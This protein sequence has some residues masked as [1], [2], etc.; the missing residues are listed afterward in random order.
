VRRSAPIF[1]VTVLAV[2]TAVGALSGCGW[3]KAGNVSHIKPS[4]FVLRGYVSV[5]RAP[6]GPTGSPCQ[7]PSAG[8]TANDPVVVTDP[9]DHVLATGVLG[10]GV[11]AADGGGYRC[12]FPFQISGVAGGHGSYGISPAGRPAVIFAATELRQ[13]KPAVIGVD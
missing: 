3:V 1:A 4:G 10:S 8:I 11:L 12:N 13:D 2:T 5:A 9:A 6:N 7:T